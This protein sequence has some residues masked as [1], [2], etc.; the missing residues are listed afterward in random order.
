MTRT[1]DPLDNEIGPD[2]RDT[3]GGPV[4]DGNPAPPGVP[5][6]ETREFAAQVA[7]QIESFLLALRAIASEADPGRAVSLLLLEISQ[8][9]LAGARMG[10]QRDFTPAAASQPDIGPEADLE[11]IR[12]AL[13][14]LLGGVD[15]YAFVFDPFAPE[16]VGSRL[17]GDLAAIAT[18]LEYGL[19]HH[20]LGNVVE[21]LWWWQFS[22]VASWGNLAGAALRALL[23]VIAH[24]RLDAAQSV[25]ETEQLAVADEILLSL[26]K[27]G[28]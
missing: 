18:D 26:G 7:A 22:Y 19:R 11:E 3:P 15:S 24:D 10:A 1:Q 8:V 2:G 28:G 27:L 17:S 13:A 21:A 12:L 16:M 5:D 9:L 14:D 4:G 25:E 23:S 20:R 6:A